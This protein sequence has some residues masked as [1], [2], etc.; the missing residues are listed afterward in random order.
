MLKVTHNAG[1]FSC[2]TVRLQKIISYFNEHKQ[3]PVV[4]SSQQ[5]ELYKPDNDASDITQT[6]FEVSDVSVDYTGPISIIPDDTEEQFSNY[7]HLNYHQLRP[8]IQRYFSISPGVK[9]VVSE[10][11]T[12]YALDYS[13]ICVVY[14]RGLGKRIET[15]LPPYREFVRKARDV[16]KEKPDTVFLVQSDET[17]F[18]QMMCDL[19]ENTIVFNDE[20]HSIPN[21]SSVWNFEDTLHKNDRIHHAINFLAIVNIMS[22]ARNV[23]CYSGNCSVWIAL[24]RGHADGFHQY[25][26]HKESIWGVPNKSYDPDQTVFWL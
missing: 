21:T 6:F 10:L 17:E 23:I 4:D 1:F 14:Y 9:T 19:F 15:I 18:V 24:F 12:K 16:L 8:F 22:K 5:F 20:I 2:C 25:L 7:K 3:L 11:E 26:H 13:R